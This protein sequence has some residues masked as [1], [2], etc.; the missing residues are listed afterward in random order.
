MGDVLDLWDEVA[1]H[2]ESC[3]FELGNMRSAWV[4]TWKKETC[5]LV[6]ALELRESVMADV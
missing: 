2:V 1:S 6:Q 3:E 5:V 4:G